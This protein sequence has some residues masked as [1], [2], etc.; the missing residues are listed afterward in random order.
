MFLYVVA[1]TLEVARMMAEV[2]H[3]GDGVV[4]VIMRKEC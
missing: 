4:V 2:L 3:T 1:G